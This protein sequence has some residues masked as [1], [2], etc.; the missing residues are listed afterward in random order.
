MARRDDEFAVDRDNAQDPLVLA[1][2]VGSTASRGAVHDAT[3]RPVGVR[4][5]VAHAFTSAADGTSQIDPDQVGDEIEQ[6]I[7]DLAGK[8][9]TG[10]I[11]GVAVD[12]F[13]SSLVGVDSD[14]QPL[15]PCYTYADSRSADFV[16]TLR[17]RLDEAKVQHRTGT[18]LHTSYLAPKLLWLQQTQPDVVRK[19]ARWLSLGEYVQQRLIGRT[20]AGT[21]IASWSGLLDRHSGQWDPELLDACR[22]GGDQLSSVQD[23]GIAIDGVD[24]QR[25]ASQWP[26]LAKASWFPSIADGLASNLGTGAADASTIGAATATSGAMRVLLDEVPDQVP[27]GLWCYRVDH[28]SLLGGAVND[29][30]RL[31]SWLRS[32]LRVSD[33]D[34]D[35]DA[36]LAADPQPGGPVVVPFLTGERSTGWAASA[37]AVFAD[38]TDATRPEQLF[39]AGAEGIAI[40]YARIAGQLQAAAGNVERVVASGR[41]GQDLPH[42]LQLLADAIDTPVEQVDLKRTTLRGTALMA[43]ETLAP[44]VRPAAPPVSAVYD[45]LHAEHYAAVRRR[46]EELYPAATAR[47]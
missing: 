43:L 12:T 3:G 29:V 31:I 41:V 38:V 39:R 11:T 6:I 23:P 16:H 20:V 27:D 30:G 34:A 13:A 22:I 37:R 25:I 7:D 1:L 18:R 46:F 36:L 44:D 5:K 45:P 8:Q 4:A 21:P 35:L 15:T 19:V 33:D 14:G 42:L 28:R 10:R 2:D 47:R 26:A 9:L 32:T 40:S 24:E 17:D